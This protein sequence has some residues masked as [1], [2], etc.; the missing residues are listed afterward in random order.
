MAGGRYDFSYIALEF[1]N[2]V[3]VICLPTIFSLGEK[4]VL[5]LKGIISLMMK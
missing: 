2:G 3:K 1:S 4:M 5:F